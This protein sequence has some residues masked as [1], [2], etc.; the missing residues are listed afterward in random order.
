MNMTAKT[1]QKGF[2]T[3]VDISGQIVLGEES[4][5][6]GKL[7]SDLLGKGQKRILLNLADVHRVDTAG[8]AYIMSGLSNVRKHKGD[9]KLLNP[10]KDLRG[11]LEITR[12]LTVIEISDDEN[13]AVKS[14]AE[15]A[16]ASA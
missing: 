14:F 15:S 13:A 5:S 3:I 7:L 6:L 4:T 9:L 11:V 12:L 1:R 10:T 16:S 2:V 8:L